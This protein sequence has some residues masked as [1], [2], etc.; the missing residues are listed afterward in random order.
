MPT[1]QATP[2]IDRDEAISRIKAA[3]KRRSGKA[4][5]VRG[6]Q[7]TAWGWITIMAQPKR[8]VEFGYMSD[9]D[10]AELATLLGLESVHQQGVNVAASSEYR[11]EYVD[12]AEGRQPSVIAEPYWD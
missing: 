5:S 1:A 11:R 3:L 8:L 4:W 2:T 6:G 9:A 7:G 12:R 10:R